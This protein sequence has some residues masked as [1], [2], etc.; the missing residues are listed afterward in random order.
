MMVAVVEATTADVGITETVVE[1][2]TVEITTEIDV[3]AKIN[4]NEEILLR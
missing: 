3:L 1:A 4:L 2:T